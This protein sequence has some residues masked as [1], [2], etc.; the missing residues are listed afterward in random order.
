MPEWLSQENVIEDGVASTVQGSDRPFH[1]EESVEPQNSPEKGESSEK[2]PPQ[3]LPATTSGL[4][5]GYEFERN[6]AGTD[7]VCGKKGFH[8]PH[9]L[10]TKKCM[11]TNKRKP[12]HQEESQQVPANNVKDC[13]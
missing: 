4:C 12:C 8:H 5:G 1:M 3:D 7:P 9:E 13:S 11:E 10:L 2:P 6:H